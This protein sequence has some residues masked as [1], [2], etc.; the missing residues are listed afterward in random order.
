MDLIIGN[1]RFSKV[2]MDGGSSLNIMYA[3]TL[4][5]M[6]IGLDKVSKEV[7]TFEVVRFQG[8]Y[9]AI[10]GLHA[11]PS[12]WRSPTTPTSNEDAGPEGCHY[13][14]LLVRTRL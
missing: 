12:L 9:H 7:L 5:L 4:E 8:A 1:T 10:L 14:R 13:H 11:T 6:G 3:H 2:L